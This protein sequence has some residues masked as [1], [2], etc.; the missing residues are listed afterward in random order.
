MTDLEAIDAVILA[1]E[2]PNRAA[3]AMG[4]DRQLLV[5]WRKKAESPD[6]LPDSARIA[7][8]REARKLKLPGFNLAFVLR[9]AA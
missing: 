4:I 5:Y 8:A 9:R 3:R 7:L 1:H 6:G 2:N